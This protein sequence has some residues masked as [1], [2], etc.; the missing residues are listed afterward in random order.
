MTSLY[1][2]VMGGGPR[3]A[4]TVGG[5]GLGSAAGATAVSLARERNDA[6]MLGLL[7]RYARVGP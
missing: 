3:S 5:A 1:L 4:A 7:Q 6:A 2:G